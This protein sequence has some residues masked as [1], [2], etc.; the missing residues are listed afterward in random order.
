[1]PIGWPPSWPTN[2]TVTLVAL[3]AVTD[4][5]LGA[6]P[7]VTAIAEVRVAVGRS[8][9][10]CTDR[11]SALALSPPKAFWK[12]TETLVALAAL[13]TALLELVATPLMVVMFASSAAW[14][15]DCNTEA[16]VL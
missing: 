7:P 14:I 4:T 11:E 8:P 12:V 15:F 5:T 6:G 13:T 16:V 9:L 10:A 3:A 2:V 1:M